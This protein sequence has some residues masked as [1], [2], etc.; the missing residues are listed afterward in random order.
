[1]TLSRQRHMLFKNEASRGN[2]SCGFMRLSIY[3]DNQDVFRDVFK[4][5]RVK[6]F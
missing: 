3:G 4:D 1:M 6:V 2:V 5:D